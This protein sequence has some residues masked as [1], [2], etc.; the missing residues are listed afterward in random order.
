[1]RFW[2]HV[3]QKEEDVLEK[4]LGPYVA[5]QNSRW[6]Q[7]KTVD[8]GNYVDHGFDESIN[9]SR[10]A[11]KKNRVKIQENIKRTLEE[12]DLH[13]ESTCPLAEESTLLWLQEKYGVLSPYLL[14]F[15]GHSS[16]ENKTQNTLHPAPS[17]IEM[18]F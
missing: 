13:F 8:W 6:I 15:Q 10:F 4:N 9:C 5:C 12:Q 2:N 18:D 14:N 16:L 11:K 3:L 17:S 7:V 1:M